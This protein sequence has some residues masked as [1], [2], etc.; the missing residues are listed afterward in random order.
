[1]GE[2]SRDNFHLS[3]NINEERWDEIFGKI[4]EELDAEELEMLTMI[5]RR[6]DPEKHYKSVD[7]FWEEYWKDWG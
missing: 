5:N 6:L 2:K 7:E 4:E 1:M 3:N